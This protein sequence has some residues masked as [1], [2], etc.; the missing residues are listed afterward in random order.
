MVR[1]NSDSRLDG[2]GDPLDPRQQMIA[3]TEAFLT[4]ALAKDRGL[5]RI[6]RRK[7]DEGGFATFLKLPVARAM[8]RHWWGRALERM[9]RS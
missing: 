3:E 1:W 9:D 8:I 5:P 4:W 7:I 2:S 6:P